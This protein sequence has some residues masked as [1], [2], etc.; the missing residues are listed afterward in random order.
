MIEPKNKSVRRIVI[1]L[2]LILTLFSGLAYSQSKILHL[3]PR[4]VYTDSPVL[5]E[6]IIDQHTTEIREVKIYYRE[7]GQAAFI[8]DYMTEFMGVFKYNIPAQF[9]TA[10]GIEYLI[11]A[12]FVDGS[13]AA[14]PEVDP[15]NV[16][17]FVNARRM[18]SEPPITL[19]AVQ[20][21]LTGGNSSDVIILS[22]E[23]AQ[24]VAASEVLIAVS[25]FNA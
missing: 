14:F 25:L 21:D 24:V 23:E 22:P 13:M 12:E 5:I 11:I 2:S 6:A 1:N 4:E 18:T 9:V 10:N 8:E 19:D 15:F 20:T 17:M 16:P 7:S 3:P